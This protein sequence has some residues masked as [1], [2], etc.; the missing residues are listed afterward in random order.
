[1][2]SPKYLCPF[3]GATVQFPI[4]SDEFRHLL[5][6]GVL[7]EYRCC[8]IK[9]PLVDTS[10][11]R[12]LVTQLPTPQVAS[13]II[14]KEYKA[15][16]SLNQEGIYFLFKIH[17]IVYVGKSHNCAKRIKGHT[18]KNNWNTVVCI[19]V[20]QDALNLTERAFIRFFSPKHNTKHQLHPPELI[21]RLIIS[22]LLSKYSNK[23]NSNKLPGTI[24]KNKNRYWW[25]VK[26]PSETKT[27]TLPL[28]PQ[29]MKF[30]TKDRQ[31]AERVATQILQSKENE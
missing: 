4:S 9:E 3:S 11:I 13:R 6:R 19:P 26:F 31:E 29:G 23:L 30:A 7:T 8:G 14:Q 17:Q 25:K 21:D 1:M 27:K 24:Y 22:H 5:K 28:R 16:T 15:T 2:L 12:K 10:E 18:G 20:L